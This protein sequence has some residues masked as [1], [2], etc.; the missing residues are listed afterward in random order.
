MT[1]VP[2]FNEDLHDLD[3]LRQMIPYLVAA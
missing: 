1:I 3:G 2:N